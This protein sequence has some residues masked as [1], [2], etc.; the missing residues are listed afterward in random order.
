MV[1]LAPNFRNGNDK[2]NPPRS[3]H[4]PR[5]SGTRPLLVL[6]GGIDRVGWSYGRNDDWRPVGCHDHPFDLLHANWRHHF[7]RQLQDDQEPTSLDHSDAGRHPLIFNLFRSRVSQVEASGTIFRRKAARTCLEFSR[8]TYI[9][10]QRVI[11][12][13]DKT[14][15]PP[16][17]PP[18]PDYTGGT[19]DKEVWVSVRRSPM[20]ENA[21]ALDT[22]VNE[23]N[24]W[25]ERYGNEGSSP[26]DQ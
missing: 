20:G 4:D 13:E 5:R 21:T 10:R 14:H 12:A 18:P 16:L 15:K 1:W 22:F 11:L 8:L 9:F 26:T 23:L 17:V 25:R 6:V 3:A 19:Y 24:S 2:R 7:F